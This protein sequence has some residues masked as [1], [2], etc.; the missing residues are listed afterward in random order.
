LTAQESA[1]ELKSLGYRLTIVTMRDFDDP[2]A[3]VRRIRRLLE[4]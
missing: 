3:L 1:A 4:A 2:A